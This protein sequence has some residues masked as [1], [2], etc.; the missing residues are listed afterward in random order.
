MRKFVAINILLILC[1]T[2]SALAYAAPVDL[3]SNMAMLQ[4]KLSKMNDK[5]TFSI[6]V[7]GDNRSGDD[8]YAEQLKRINAKAP[9][10]IAHTGDKTYSGLEKE[11]QKFIKIHEKNDIPFFSIAG[12]HEMRLSNDERYIKYFGAKD[13]SFDIGS[14]AFIFVDSTAGFY[15]SGISDASFKLLEEACAKY[16]DKRIFVFVHHPTFDP[17]VSHKSPKIMDTKSLARFNAIMDKYKVSYVFFGHNHIYGYRD[18]SG[19]DEYI[20]GG[21]GSPL[22]AKKSEGGYY[23]YLWLDITKND[24]KI[25]VIKYENK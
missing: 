25:S 3:T 14:N 23:H 22:Y 9:L 24:V 7:M 12:N 5:E 1:L 16:K 17:V 11:Y 15:S 21:A 18:M 8:I 6:V 2:I 10:F 20:T 13:Y 19:R 4:D